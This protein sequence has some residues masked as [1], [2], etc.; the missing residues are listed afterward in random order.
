MVFYRQSESFQRAVVTALWLASHE[1]LKAL[2]PWHSTII[3]VQLPQVG[4]AA[5]EGS[6]CISIPQLERRILWKAAFR[7]DNSKTL[8]QAPRS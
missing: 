7:G 8:P 5:A 1:V 6:F 4:T 3:T 2:T